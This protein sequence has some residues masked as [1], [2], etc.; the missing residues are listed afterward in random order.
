MREIGECAH[1]A[2]LTSEVRDRKEAGGHTDKLALGYFL[3]LNQQQKIRFKVL[4]RHRKD[5]TFQ[6]TFLYT[7]LLQLSVN[8]QVIY[9]FSESIQEFLKTYHVVDYIFTVTYTKE[10]SL[11]SLFMWQR[12]KFR[13]NWQ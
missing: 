11:S 6:I 13:M 4:Y 3:Y 2:A 7:L 10:V 1:Y 9:L 12:C 8:N 5:K